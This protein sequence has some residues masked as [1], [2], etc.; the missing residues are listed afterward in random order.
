MSYVNTREDV[1]LFLQTEL[2]KLQREF[3]IT[4]MALFGSFAKG[5]QTETSDV[6]L[7]IES[8]HS[9]GFKFFELSDYLENGLGRKVDLIT[10]R[11]MEDSKKKP[12]YKNIAETVER[13]LLYV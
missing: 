3:G 5:T 12:R 8:S 10:F 4:K 7:L 1:F 11:Q 13:S 2:P 9:L 6:D